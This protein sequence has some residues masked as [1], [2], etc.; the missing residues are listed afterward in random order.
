MSAASPPRP[1]FF[2]ITG[3]SVPRRAGFG[4]LAALMLV[5]MEMLVLP[6]ELGIFELA[7]VALHILPQWVAV[8]VAIATI[9][10]IAEQ[11]RSPVPLLALA[12]V[13]FAVATSVVFELIRQSM[14]AMGL[15]HASAFTSHIDAVS[16]I[17]YDAWMILFFGGMYLIACRLALRAE[18]IRDALA[19][20]LIEQARIESELADTQLQALKARVDPALVI[21]AMNEVAARYGNSP[22]DGAALLDKVVAYLRAATPAVRHP[23]HP[24][25]ADPAVEAALRHLI[26][27]I[28]GT[29]R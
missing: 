21:R 7:V 9:A 10:T 8:A 17:A 24:P 29:R 27:D 5:A 23:G 15:R 18:A 25:E 22:D 12:F 20:S 11:R 26:A 13:A 14:D 4:V 3:F 28:E 1:L 6:P 19:R 2:G 16:T